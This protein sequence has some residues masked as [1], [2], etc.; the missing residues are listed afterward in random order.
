MILPDDENFLLLFRRE[1][2]LDN[3]V[4]FM[5]VC[6]SAFA[7]SPCTPI[8]SIY[9]LQQHYPEELG[10]A[11]KAHKCIPS[12]FRDTEKLI[13]G[14]MGARKIVKYKLFFFFLHKFLQLKVLT[15]QRLLAV[16]FILHS[17]WG[18]LQIHGQLC[19]NL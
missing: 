15:F 5:R 4:E 13:F 12:L 17:N 6:I 7:L 2:P 11:V 18:L 19:T 14:R 16:A 1:T 10:Q 9:A 3:S 8:A